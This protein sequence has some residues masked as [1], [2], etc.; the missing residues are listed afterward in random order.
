MKRLSI[1]TMCFMLV[2]IGNL[3]GATKP[4]TPL[5]TQIEITNRSKNPCLAGN[6]EKMIL[7][8]P[9]ET[10]NKAEPINNILFSPLLSFDLTPQTKSAPFQLKPSSRGVWIVCGN[11]ADNSEYPPKLPLPIDSEK[12]LLELEP[13]FE[14]MLKFYPLSS[15]HNIK[16]INFSITKDTK[17]LLIKYNKQSYIFKI[18]PQQKLILSK[19]TKTS[20]STITPSIK[21]LLLAKVKLPTPYQHE[22]HTIQYTNTKTFKDIKDLLLHYDIF[23]LLEVPAHKKEI[24]FKKYYQQEY[25]T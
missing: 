8:Q 18:A 20:Q 4:K 1:T 12:Q 16:K 19:A 13:K 25:Q 21:N 14:Q 7:L 9:L 10:T 22:T 23:F 15:V 11:N 17:R 24:D 6:Y 3:Y 2:S 5:A